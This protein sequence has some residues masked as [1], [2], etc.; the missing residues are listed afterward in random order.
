MSADARA[1]EHAYCAT[2]SIEPGDHILLM[3]DGFY[4]LI[5]TFNLYSPRNFMARATA[6]NGLSFLYNELRT[7]E[8]SDP[9]G[10]LYPR[11]KKSD[12][13]TALLLTIE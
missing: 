7:V 13:A 11:V 1:A 8:D 10:R 4:R 6:P 9:D 3:S 12:D 5:D 2:D